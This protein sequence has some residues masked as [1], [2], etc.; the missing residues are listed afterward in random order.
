MVM[1]ARGWQKTGRK[2][3]LGVRIAAS[4]SKPTHNTGGLAFWFIRAERYERAGGMPFRTVR[5]RC[6]KLGSTK[7]RTSQNGRRT[8]RPKQER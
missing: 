7:P 1:E 5:E 6:N 2:G 8:G 4:S 3:S